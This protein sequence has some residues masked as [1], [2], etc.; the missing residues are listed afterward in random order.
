MK[1]YQSSELSRD[2]II[3][4]EV[5]TKQYVDNQISGG[6]ITGGLFFTNAAPTSTGIVANKQYVANTVPSNKVISEA[7]ADTAAVTVTLFAEGGSSFYSPTVTIVTDP[8]QAGGAITC[9][10]VEDASDKR[11]YTATAALNVAVTTTVTATS[12]TNAT[13]TMVINRA[14]AGPAMDALLIGS[15]VS[16]AVGQTEVRAGQQFNVSGRVPNDAT[17]AEV[18][19]TGA[20]A[21]VISLTLGAADSMGTGYKT[22]TGVVTVSSATGAQTVTGRAR[23]SLGTYGVNF[24]STNTITLNQTFPVIGARSITYPV[25]QTALK[26]SETATVAATITNFDTVTYTASNLSVTDPTTYAAT[27]TVTRTGGTYSVGTANYTITATKTSNNATSSAT[28]AVSIADTAPSAAI[29]IVGSPSRLLSSPTGTDYTVTITANQQL[30]TAPSL[31]ASSGTWQGSWSGSGTTWTRVLRIFDTSP[32]GVQSFSGL[33]VVGL[34]GVVGSTITSGSAYTVGGFA[35]RTITF[36]AFARYA[37]IGTSIVDI[38][39]TQAWYTGA[40]EL[41]L[42]TDTG[43]YFQGFTIVDASG[44]YSA[45]GSYLYISDAAF[46]GANTTGTLQLDIRETA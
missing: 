42:Y 45:T 21:S 31:T 2:P 44:N 9:T 23:N 38:T 26:A 19:A 6:A 13:A 14:G 36:P 4:M 5:A 27:K 24:V 25:G 11:T 7:T 33:T 1:I 46:A 43:D 18:L 28:A 20:S 15:I 40:A 29:T 39:K 37:F 17:Y 22:V 8:P 32:K 35:Q 10:L 30:S 34:A 16:P 41:T 12:S 3:P